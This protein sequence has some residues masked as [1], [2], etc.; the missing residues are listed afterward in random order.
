MDARQQSAQAV[1]G[2]ADPEG[3]APWAMQLVARVEKACPPN[4]TAVLEAAAMATV[5]LLD[6]A[7]AQG[8]WRPAI[9]RWLAG[10]IRKHVRRAR[11][12]KWE[13][14]QALPGLTVTHA[15]AE[16]RA[17]VPTSTDAIYPLVAKMQL[18]GSDLKD[19]GPRTAL[20]PEP[21][22]PMVAVSAET[23][24]SWT[25]QAAATGHA[26]QIARM[27]MPAEKLAQWRANGFAVRV[28]QPDDARWRQLVEAA[29]VRVV[30]AGFTFPPQRQCESTECEPVTAVARWS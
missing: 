30:D 13:Q 27:Q 10:R 15:G 3:E 8:D 4:R 7:D 14:A 19:P 23:A 22:V 6:S 28:E 20:D 9:D 21:G 5:Q 2:H 18:S 16:V 29:D 26:T 1:S 25:K 17:F 11:G 12:A 24:M